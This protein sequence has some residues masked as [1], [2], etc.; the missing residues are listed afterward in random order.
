M[1]QHKIDQTGIYIFPCG[2]TY[3]GGWYKIKKVVGAPG[4][5]LWEPAM[6]GNSRTAGSTVA[7]P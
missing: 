2:G 6:S 7:A 1:Q 4:R 5:T 3:V